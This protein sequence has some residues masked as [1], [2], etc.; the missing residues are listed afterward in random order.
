[1]VQ[2]SCDFLP[3]ETVRADRIQWTA[4]QAIEPPDTNLP[5]PRLR[6]FCESP[7]VFGSEQPTDKLMVHLYLACALKTCA[8]VECIAGASSPTQLGDLH[9]PRNA[10]KSAACCQR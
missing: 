3:C 2:C 4:R 7:T 8:Q 9:R 6:R 10:L 5:R 1:C